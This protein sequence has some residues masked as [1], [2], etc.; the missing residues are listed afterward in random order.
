MRYS[1]SVPA[2]SLAAQGYFFDLPDLHLFGSQNIHM[3][4]ETWNLSFGKLA[5]RL[6]RISI[7]KNELPNQLNSQPVV[8]DRDKIAFQIFEA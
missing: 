8:S 7:A 3:H 6:L 5:K 2:K 1:V 4:I